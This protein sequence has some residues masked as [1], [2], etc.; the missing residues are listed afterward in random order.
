MPQLGSRAVPLLPSFLQISAIRIDSA[1]RACGFAP[2]RE[3][4][5]SHK[6]AHPSM[7]KVQLPGNAQD[8]S[9]LPIP[10]LD[11]LIERKPLLPCSLRTC[12]LATGSFLTGR[13]RMSGC[14]ACVSWHLGMAEKSLNGFPKIFQEMPAVNHL[15]GLWSAVGCSTLITF[16]TISAD[17]FYTRMQP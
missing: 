12:S 6:L 17:D 7:T 5:R 10:F 1:P 11:L 8:R 3:T 13:N 16:G 15:L 2:F 14:F 4:C 9:S